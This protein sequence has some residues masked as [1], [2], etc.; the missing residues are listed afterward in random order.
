MLGMVL[1]LPSLTVGFFCDDYIHLLAIQGIDVGGARPFDLYRF[2]VG[3]PVRTGA[4]ILRGPWMW[5][6]EPGIRAAF[7][8]PIPSALEGLEF[9][10]FRCNP[11]G[12][13]AHAVLWYGAFITVVGVFYRR[14]LAPAT[15]LLA[16]V[17]FAVD[18]CHA[19]SVG[20]LAARYALLAAV[21]STLALYGYWRYRTEGR[22]ADLGLAFV[23]YAVSLGCGES[24]LGVP[25][26]L[27][28]FELF[29]T[30]ARRTRIRS[31]VPFAGLTLVYLVAHRLGGYGTWGSGVYTDPIAEPARYAAESPLRFVTLLGGLISS[32][33]VDVGLLVPQSRLPLVL[34]GAVATL[35]FA[36]LLRAKLRAAEADERRTLLT[37]TVGSMLALVPAVGA[38]TGARLLTFSSV[39]AIAV[40]AAVAEHAWRTQ[41]L[42]VGAVW[43]VAFNLVLPPL[44]FVSQLSAVKLRSDASGRVLSRFAA[45]ERRPRVALLRTT[46]PFV[47]IYGAAQLPVE[48]GYTPEIWNLFATTARPLRFTRTAERTFDVEVLEGQLLDSDLEQVWRLDHSMT[49]G[50]AVHTESFDVRVTAVEDGRPR[51]LSL[52]LNDALD[53]ARTAYVVQTRA[54]LEPFP[55]PALGDSVTLPA[56]PSPFDP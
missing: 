4:L 38:P 32:A 22:R 26:Y 15:A 44:L 25:C 14:A 3:D 18:E 53:S 52:V 54:G 20:W 41:S 10:L 24:A 1:S 48:H 36:W 29:A 5:W 55:F 56:G 30:D 23:A 12:Y 40:I 46:D 34:V 19:A 28:A 8:R 11:V 2:A 21:F 39:G 51:R 47:G 37:L 17:M 45:Q 16:L 50:Y 9:L 13:H 6:A 49:E 35:A 43:L 31:L 33:P 7:F 27:F 42:R